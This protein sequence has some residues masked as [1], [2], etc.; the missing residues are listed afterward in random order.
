MGREREARGRGQECGWSQDCRTQRATAEGGVRDVGVAK[1][2]KL[3]LDPAG[4]VPL[5]K[6]GAQIGK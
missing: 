3:N 5:T 6:G 1:A 2:G 4:G